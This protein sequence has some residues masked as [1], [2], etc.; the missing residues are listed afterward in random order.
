MEGRGSTQCY[1]YILPKN[2]S[3]PQLLRHARK[4]EQMTYTLGKKKATE[5]SCK[6][7]PMLG[8]TDKDF[9]VVIINIF[10]ELKVTVVKEVCKV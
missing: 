4:Q 1:Y 7:D 10:R 3:F 6:N 5:T 9:E 2:S 8:L